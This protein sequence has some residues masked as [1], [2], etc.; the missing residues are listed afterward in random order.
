MPQNISEIFGHSFG[1]FCQNDPHFR[2]LGCKELKGPV[3]IFSR[4]PLSTCEFR[5]WDFA[6]SEFVWPSSII[7]Q[8]PLSGKAVAHHNSSQ[9]VDMIIISSMIQCVPLSFICSKCILPDRRRYPPSP[10]LASRTRTKQNEFWNATLAR[11]GLDP[12][13]PG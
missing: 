8:N 4:V 10:D 1:R 3:R 11:Y 7:R 5:F 2:A 9:N 13:P 6:A 12:R